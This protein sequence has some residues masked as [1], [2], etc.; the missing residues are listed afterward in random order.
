MHVTTTMAASH[1]QHCASIVL[2]INKDDPSLKRWSTHSIQ[3]MAANLLHQANLSHTY[4]Q[5][6]L[7]WKSSLLLVYLRNT[8]YVADAHIKAVNI[9]L[10]TKEQPKTKTSY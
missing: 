8:I 10:G 3:F 1:L 6:H 2:N 4:M 9:N 5:T 7:R